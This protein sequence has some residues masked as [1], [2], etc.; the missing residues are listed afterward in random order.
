M[1]C[2]SMYSCLLQ[3]LGIRL[4]SFIEIIVITV[5][6]LVIALVYSWSITFVILGLIPLIAITQG[7]QTKVMAGA[8]ASARK[9]YEESANVM[10]LFDILWLYVL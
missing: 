7:V 4:G 10:C 6:S 2:A 8:T 1:R 9:G 5:A 3:A